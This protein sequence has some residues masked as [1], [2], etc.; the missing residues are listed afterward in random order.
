MLDLAMFVP[1]S[2]YL[3]SVA[4]NCTRVNTSTMNFTRACTH[5][6]RGV[7]MRRFSCDPKDV[8]SG[9]SPR[10]RVKAAEIWDVHSG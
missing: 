4:M 3:F 6:T 7:G 5:H 10:G 8:L 1:V 2:S 9:Y